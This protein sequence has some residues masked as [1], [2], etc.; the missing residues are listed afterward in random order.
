M[1]RLAAVGEST[2]VMI[3]VAALAR[4]TFV[5]GE[6]VNCGSTRALEKRSFGTLIAE[7]NR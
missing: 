5:S 7:V 6:Y 4:P 3:R 1:R 2:A